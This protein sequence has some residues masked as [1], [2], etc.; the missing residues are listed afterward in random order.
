MSLQGKRI[1]F[2]L[3]GSH[4]TYD[5]VFP[6]IEKLVNEG[7]EVIPIVTST[8]QNTE[9]RFGKGED[10]IERIETLTGNHVVDTIVKAEPLGP[11]LPLDCMVIAPLTGNSMSKMA[12]ALTDSPVLMAAKATMRNHRPVVVA[13]STNDALGL[14]GV[15]L[16]RLMAAKDI[17]FVPYG[18][19]NPIGKPSSMVARMSMIRDTIV[20]ALEREQV[21]PVIVER[22]KDDID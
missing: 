21:Q 20:A 22:F 6:E 9:T 7:A 4:C 8:V 12:N 1:G 5:E 11:R 18:Q 14:N 3:T 13:I 19:D 17:Y 16:M 15:N 10:W 2:G